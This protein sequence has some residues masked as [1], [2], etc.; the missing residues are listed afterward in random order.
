MQKN[1]KWLLCCSV[2]II[3]A[4]CDNRKDIFKKEIGSN[5]LTLT[6]NSGQ[7]MEVTQGNTLDS[8]KIDKPYSLRFAFEAKYKIQVLVT[9]TDPLG[10]EII[11][12]EMNYA[13]DITFVPTLLGSYQLVFSTSD[14]YGQTHQTQVNITCFENLPPVAVLKTFIEGRTITLDASESYD[15]DA[16]YGGGLVEYFFALTDGQGVTRTYSQQDPFLRLTLNAGDYFIYLKV[17]DNEP[18]G[19]WSEEVSTRITIKN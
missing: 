11:K 14:I 12:K 1:W 16:I 15:R 13:G 4:A 6:L 10:K 19:V 8:A 3:L 2:F 7:T 5:R 18:Q 9:L 17:R